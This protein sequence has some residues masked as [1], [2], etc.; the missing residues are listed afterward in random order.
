[1][2]HVCVSG[3]PDP[4]GHMSEME[5]EQQGAS[6]DHNDKAPNRSSSKVSGKR[7]GQ[8]QR[9]QVRPMWLRWY[10]WRVGCCGSS[11]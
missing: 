3:N 10:D 4:G 9:S 8:G 6:P 5:E 7:R 11:G 2:E 1:M